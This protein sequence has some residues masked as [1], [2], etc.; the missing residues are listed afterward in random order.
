M[1]SEV[2]SLVETYCLPLQL[3][4]AMLGMGAT[5]VPR[6]FLEVARERQALAL[7]VFLQLLFVPLLSLGFVA[8]FGLTR[9]WAVGLLLLAVVPGGAVSNLYTFV[10]RGNTALSVTLTALT[11]LAAVVTIP[12]MLPLLTGGIEIELPA[13]LVFRDIVLYLLA[14]LAAGMVLRRA[15]PVRA[16]RVSGWAVRASLVLVG[17]ITVSALGSGRIDVAEYGWGPPLIVLAFCMTLALLTPHLSRALGRPDD[18]TV[19]LA[20]E[21]VVRNVGIALLLLP[22][23]FPGE[24]AQA[25]VLYTC[26]F[27]AGCSFFVA[28]PVLLRHRMGHGAV[29]LRSPFPRTA[30]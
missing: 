4:L 26:L 25:H 21:V 6:D 10:G 9:G 20:V 15:A 14:P 5:L 30:A 8:A 17:L 22:F 11:T 16:G 13:H 24:P 28:L 7:G 2:H 27:Y 1:S 19:A 29:L 23:C 3:V 18:D 12:L